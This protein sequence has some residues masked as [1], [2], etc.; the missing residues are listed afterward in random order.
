MGSLKVLDLAGNHMVRIGRTVGTLRHLVQL[1][2]AENR[3]STLP[4][5]IGKLANLR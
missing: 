4:P 1:S 2:L 5:E 3:I